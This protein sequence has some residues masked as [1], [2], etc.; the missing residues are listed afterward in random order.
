MFAEQLTK[1]K[2]CRFQPLGKCTKGVSCPFAHHRSEVKS[3]P[4]LRRTKLCKALLQ[5]GQCDNPKTC[6]YAH[7]REELRSTDAFQK[8]KLCRN[9]Q[10][11][12]CSRGNKCHFAHSTAEL[13]APELTA[14]ALQLPPGLESLFGFG[15]DDENT[16]YMS[17]EGSKYSGSDGGGDGASQ[18]NA[19][20]D[21]A[22][23]PAYVRIGS[24]VSSFGGSPHGVGSDVSSFGGSP[25]HG[26][27]DDDSPFFKTGLG[28]YPYTT[29][30]EF[31]YLASFSAWQ[32]EWGMD[33]SS[34]M[35]NYAN[36]L[37]SLGL[38]GMN[39]WDWG[40]TEANI[41]INSG[42]AKTKK[43]IALAIETI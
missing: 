42:E 15:E 30:T 7:N 12:K 11:G 8:T 26:G 22:Y 6:C 19:T 16:T 24:D 21:P 3:Q 18:S 32:G 36:A 41:N 27:V 4:D 13:K 14:A 39:G 20:N 23:E 37:A 38:N 28:G 35:Q 17:G 33:D 29:G 9:L 40:V 25:L 5:T 10:F 31:D 34:S 1:T 2:M 43:T